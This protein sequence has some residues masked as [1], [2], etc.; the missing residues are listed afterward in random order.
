MNTSDS[1][2]EIVKITLD[3]MEVALKIAGTGAKNLAVMIYTILKNKEQTKGK[4]RLSSMIRSG[5]SLEIFT[6]KAEDL[7]KFKDEAKKYGILYCVLANKNNSK[8]DGMVDVMIR[9]DDAPKM[10]RIA[11]RFNFEDVATIERKL[12]QEKNAKLE[13]EKVEQ[14]KSANEKFIDDIM[15]V[16]KEEQNIIPS[17]DTKETEEK[18]LSEISSNTKPKDKMEKSKHKKSVIKELNEIKQ[19]QKKEQVANKEMEKNKKQKIT[20]KDKKA[21]HY[22]KKTKQQP[23]KPKHYANSKRQPKHLEKTTRISK[24]MSKGKGTR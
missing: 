18:N 8:I 6:M 2:E 17:N 5:K 24:N 1:A 23:Y 16:D 7:K 11:Q 3:G 12:E 14:E 15:P 19:E 10:S 20:K 21:K 9:E 22:E 4:A 13:K